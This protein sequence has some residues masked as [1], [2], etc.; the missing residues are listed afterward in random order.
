MD[1]YFMD[2]QKLSLKHSLVRQDFPFRKTYFTIGSA[3]QL[4]MGRRTAYFSIEPGDIRAGSR[5]RPSC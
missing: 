1:E 4:V 2:N 5:N 3:G